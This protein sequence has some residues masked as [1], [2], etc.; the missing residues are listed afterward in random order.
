MV[1][2]R[3]AKFF[4]IIFVLLIVFTFIL[5]LSFFVSAVNDLM[6]LQGNVKQNGLNLASGNLTVVI[7][8]AYSAGNII[9]NSTGEF[10]NS[11]NDG[12]YD[13]LLGNSTNELSLEYGKFYFIEMYVNNEKFSFNG[14]T[15]QIFQSSVGNISISEL[16]SNENIVFRNNSVTFT[17]GQ[18]VSTGVGG[19][20]KGL[21]NWIIGSS[22]ANY[23]SFNG[24]TLDLTTNVTQ[25]LYNQTYSGSTYNA[26]YALWAYNQ[27]IPALIISNVSLDILI[28]SSISINGNGTYIKLGAINSTKISYKNVTDIPTC[29]GNS[30]LF[31][32]GAS[33]SCKAV[34]T[35]NETYSI[36]AYNQTYSGSTYNATYALWAYN[37]TQPFTDWLSTFLYNYNQ[38]TPAITDINSRYWNRTQ[39]YNNTQI[40]AFGYVSSTVGNA[41]YRLRSDTINQNNVSDFFNN[42]VT[43]AIGNNTYAGIVWNYN[44]TI[45]SNIFN[46]QLNTT[47]NATFYNITVS[48]EITINGVKVSTWLFNQ[49]NIQYNFNQSAIQY[50]FNQPAIAY[51]FNQ[52][53]ILYNYN[54]SIQN[55]N[56]SFGQNLTAYSCSG[57]DKVTG[58]GGNGT[59][60]CGTDSTADTNSIS[61]LSLSSIPNTTFSTIGNNT[62]IK[63]GNAITNDS[64]ANLTSLNVTGRF[65][66]NKTL[67]VTTAG[68]VGIGT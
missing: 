36:W 17:N 21:F 52:S 10:N 3:G 8:D 33:L 19:W 43:S 6:S 1:I 15:R 64:N 62:Y 2:K 58:I 35:F 4:A 20:F 53:N 60:I 27:T 40:D 22:S 18:N 54:Q 55:L 34:S 50:N 28:N 24:S 63:L 61:N 29:S 67:Y 42:V 48:N 57:T 47:S 41:T 25:W 7:F 9:Y 16:I 56:F 46:Q 66:A 12:K 59:M 37:Q 51:N 32:D 26:T 38:T 30:M 68:N 44:Q 14:S 13:V 5:S 49:S 11:I 39:T 23:L 45:A 65:N 31:F